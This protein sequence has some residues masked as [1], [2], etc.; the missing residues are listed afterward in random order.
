M[1]AKTELTRAIDKRPAQELLR[2]GPPPHSKQ[3]IEDGGSGTIDQGNDG[4]GICRLSRTK[5]KSHEW[6]VRSL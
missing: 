3:E 4:I 2:A 1:V 5:N 6:T